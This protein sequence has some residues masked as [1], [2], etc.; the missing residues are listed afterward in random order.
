MFEG[1]EDLREARAHRGGDHH[2]A[3]RLFP[4]GEQSMDKTA[5]RQQCITPPEDTTGY[6]KQF[7]LC[8][9]HAVNS[10]GRWVGLINRPAFLAVI[11]P[12]LKIVCP[13]RMVCR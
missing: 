4:T 1:D 10:A 11:V 13:R 8:L 12:F 7:R 9:A 2:V 6:A 3:N 5:R